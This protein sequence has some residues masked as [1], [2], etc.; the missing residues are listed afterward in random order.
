MIPSETT[1]VTI[2]PFRP[3]GEAA[4]LRGAQGAQN[5]LNIIRYYGKPSP[6][7]DSQSL[8]VPSPG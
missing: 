5:N 4:G 2:I 8:M 1:R 3:A 6:L 7:S